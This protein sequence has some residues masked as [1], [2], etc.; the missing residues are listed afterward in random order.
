M[1]SV[2]IY[3]TSYSLRKYDVVPCSSF[4]TFKATNFFGCRLPVKPLLSLA[5]RNTPRLRPEPVIS[6]STHTFDVVIIGAG[7]IGLTIAR[8]FLTGS[9][10]SVAVVDKAVP[11]AG[12]TGAGSQVIELYD[13]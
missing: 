8:Q 12:A 5:A 1:A 13:Y 9:N 6:A 4:G 3:S 10:L 2:S 11:C 7:I